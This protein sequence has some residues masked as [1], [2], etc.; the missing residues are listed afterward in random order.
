MHIRAYRSATVSQTPPAGLSF[1][2][3]YLTVWVFLG[4]AAERDTR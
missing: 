1:L 4:T 3:R 2:N